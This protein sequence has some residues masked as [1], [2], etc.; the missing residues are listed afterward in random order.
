[1]LVERSRIIPHRLFPDGYVQV[2]VREE[3]GSPGGETEDLDLEGQP[4]REIGGAGHSEER[5]H[6][7]NQPRN[8][9]EDPDE[10]Q[11]TATQQETAS[12]ASVPG[13]C[14]LCNDLYMAPGE[15]YS[16]DAWKLKRSSMGGCVP[17]F[18]LN[19]GLSHFNRQ[20][21]SYTQQPNIHSVTLAPTRTAL[22]VGFVRMHHEDTIHLD[23]YTLEGNA[24]LSIAII[25]LLP[26]LL[27]IPLK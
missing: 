8:R 4:D 7:E 3:M 14:E 16:I 10:I 20:W 23:F 1:M 17:C 25:S 15:L 19:N 5:L 13:I 11:E 9:D 18:I 26:R 12:S 21:D 6:T 22:Q 24:L 2:T 27:L